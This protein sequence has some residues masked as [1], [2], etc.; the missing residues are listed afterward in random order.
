ML[1]TKSP[2]QIEDEI[3]DLLL[4]KNVLRKIILIRV[5][6][7]LSTGKS[8]DV[9]FSNII[10]RLN[11]NG[12]YYVLRN[13]SKL[14]SKDFNEVKVE[15]SE[16]IE[17]DVINNNI[18]Q[19]NLEGFDFEKII[20]ELIFELDDERQEGETVNSYEKRIIEKIDRILGV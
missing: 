9:N 14:V 13:T 17:A 3:L 15:P 5:E 7:E 18:S 11:E 6:G 1:I 4:S 20:Y 16:N 19:V 10:E 12:A 8:S 2:K